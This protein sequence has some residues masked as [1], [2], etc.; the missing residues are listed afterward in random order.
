MRLFVAAFAAGIWLLQQQADLRGLPWLAALIG[1]VVLLLVLRRHLLKVETADR[2][3]SAPA[4]RRF[5]A[6]ALLIVAAASLGFAWAAALAQLRLADELPAAL[7]GRDIELTGVVAGLPQALE[8]GVRF[9]FDVEQAVAGVPPAISLAWYRGRDATRMTRPAPRGAS[10]RRRA[11]AAHRAPEAP[12]RQPQ[13]PR[14][15]LRGLAVRTRRARHRLCA[16]GRGQPAPGCLRLAARVCVE[17]LRERVRER[18]RAP[19]R[20]ATMPACWWRWWWA[21]SAPST[22]GSGSSSPAPASRT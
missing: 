22:A 2:E 14:L 7:E 4:I 13:S 21:T 8:R 19:C 6:P 11:L 5:A 12:A 3:K 16:D 20:S 1:A 10:A 17:M 18:F 15:R 9:E